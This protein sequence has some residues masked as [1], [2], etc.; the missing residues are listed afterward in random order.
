MLLVLI[1]SASPTATNEYPQHM[2]FS[3][4]KKNIATF[5]L[6]KRALSKAMLEDDMVNFH[7]TCHSCTAMFPSLQTISE[8]LQGPVVQSIVSLTSS[9]VM[10]MLT[11]L[12]STISNP[13]VFLL[14][15]CE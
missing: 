11:I 2:F 10:K 4:N 15:K 7:W 1:R 8:T 5:W 3:S 9:L 14:N 6:K 12:V 13:Q